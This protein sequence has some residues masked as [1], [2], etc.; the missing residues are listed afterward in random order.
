MMSFVDDLI[1][2]VKT[3][4]RAKMYVM[5][6]VLSAIVLSA[7]SMLLLFLCMQRASAC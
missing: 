6:T 2:P 1:Y 5:F 4:C 7:T 3:L